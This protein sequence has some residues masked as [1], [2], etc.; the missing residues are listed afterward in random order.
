[1]RASCLCALGSI[2][3]ARVNNACDFCEALFAQ[4]KRGGGYRGL[5]GF[6]D[7]RYA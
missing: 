5:V 3:P 4:M 6:E 7:H 1:M 2:V